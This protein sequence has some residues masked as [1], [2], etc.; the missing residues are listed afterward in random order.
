M[1]RKQTSP[2]LFARAEGVRASVG[3]RDEGLMKGL[4]GCFARVIYF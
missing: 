4:K 2:Q 3:S 1:D